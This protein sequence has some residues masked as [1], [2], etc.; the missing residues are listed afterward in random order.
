MIR[1]AVT[2]ANIFIDLIILDAIQHLFNINLQIHTTREVYDQL[3]LDQKLKVEVFVKQNLL[4]VYNFSVEEINDIVLLEF[5]RGLEPADRTV[6]YYAKKSSSIVLSGDKKLR[7]YC[8]SNGLEVFGLI[9]VFDQIVELGQITKEEAIIKL[10]KLIS[11]N[12]R[13]PLDEILK[14]LKKWK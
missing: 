13:L 9:W 3:N 7:K 8:S 4:V 1:V 14:R 10:E 5:P 2:D 11:Y 6:Y 12:D